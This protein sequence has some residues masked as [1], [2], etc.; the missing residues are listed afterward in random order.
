MV[1][2]IGYIAG[3]LIMISFIPQVI[4]SYKTKSVGDLSLTT[5][6]FTMVGQVLWTIYGFA[7]GSYPVGVMNGLFLLVVIVQLYLKMAGIN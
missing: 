1:E 5:I 2:A 3:F 7:I 6:I 4:Q